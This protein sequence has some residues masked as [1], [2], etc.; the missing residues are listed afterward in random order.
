M[1]LFQ[2]NAEAPAACN[3]VTLHNGPSLPE[4]VETA[5]TTIFNLIVEG[6]VI[7]AICNLG[8]EMSNFAD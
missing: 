7:W 3:V 5:V 1:D 2:D 6:Y 4:M 8:L